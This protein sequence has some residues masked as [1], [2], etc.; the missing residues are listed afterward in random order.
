MEMMNGVGDGPIYVRSRPAKDDFV[1]TPP[2]PL[3]ETTV[4]D[5]LRSSGTVSRFCFHWTSKLFSHYF[6]TF[7]YTSAFI[8]TALCDVEYMYLRGLLPYR[9]AGLRSTMRGQQAESPLV[10]KRH[11]WC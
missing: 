8:C 7:S 3:A 5:D 4:T 9:A 6:S 1:K 2:L 10:P 11:S